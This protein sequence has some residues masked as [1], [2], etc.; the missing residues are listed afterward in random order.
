MVPR[1]ARGWTGRHKNRMQA[2]WVRRGVPVEFAPGVKPRGF[3]RRMSRKMDAQLWEER[4]KERNRSIEIGAFTPCQSQNAGE[5]VDAGCMI[6]P[7]FLV[8]KKGATNKFRAIADLRPVNAKC[9]KRTAKFQGLRELRHLG[10]KG[11]WMFTWDLDSG[12]MNLQIFGPHQKYMVL[13]LGEYMAADGEPISQSNPRFVKCNAM[14]FGWT[15]SPYFFVKL[16][17]IVQQELSKRGVTCPMWLDDGIVLCDTRVLALQHREILEE[18]LADFGLRRQPTKGQW[19]PTQDTTHLGVGVNTATGVFYVTRER[20]QKL[21]RMGKAILC[22]AKR[23][24]RWLGAR[25]LAEFAGLAMSTYDAVSAARYQLRDIFDVLTAHKV[26]SRG[27]GIDVKL[28]GQALNALQWWVDK[29]TPATQLPAKPIW[30]PPVTEVLTTDASGEGDSDA[31]GGGWGATLGGQPLNLA[32]PGADNGIAV[33]GIWSV[34]DQ[35]LHITPKELKAVKFA[36]EHWRTRLRG[37]HCL[38]WEDNQAVCGILRNLS[39][40]SPGMRED[41]KEIMDLLEDEN[42]MLQVR[43]IRSAVNP[44][45][46]YSRV[47]DKAQWRLD[48]AVAS[49]LMHRWGW[50][51][52]DRFADAELTQLQRFNAAYPCRG[53]EAVDCFTVSWEGTHSWVNPPWR[54]IGRILYKLER[55]PAASAVLLLPVWET[56]TWWPRLLNLAAERLPLALQPRHFI[57]GSLMRGGLLPEPL[58]NSGWRMQLVF[59]PARSA[60]PWSQSLVGQT[61]GPGLAAM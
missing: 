22:S 35:D 31:V 7:S 45:D 12:F 32:P 38:L 43:Y 47:S 36:L 16:L 21:V 54:D 53:A 29:M 51:D 46:F 41:L 13:D 15:N 10:Q 55:E 14:P 19:E 25:W 30:R 33:R 9:R 6:C 48:P 2:R 37:K 3:H 8:P 39:T 34:E 56:A 17:K 58:R 57:P 23:N 52:V 4:K 27:Y 26:H 11:C 50:A 24:R 44:S 49:S 61:I 60:T 18:V 28:T 42:I 59:V 1:C 5:L 20:K 40:K